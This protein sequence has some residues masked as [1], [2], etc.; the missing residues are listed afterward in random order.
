MATDHLTPAE[1]RSPDDPPGPSLSIG[2]LAARSGVAATTL[3][4]W[5]QRFGF[6]APVRT[7]GGQRRYDAA[8]VA[9]VRRVNRARESG[10]TLGAAI[11]V[12]DMAG[13]EGHRSLFADLR[14][15]HPHVDPINVS[16]R[17]MKALTWSIE[18]ECLAHA[19]RPQL[20]GCF[21]DR[22]SFRLAGRRWRE[23]AR[24]ASSAT[25]FSDFPET[26]PGATPAHVA[27]PQDSP[28]LNEW[29]LVCADRQMSVVLSA[30]EPPRTDSGAPRR[31][32]ALL[33]LEPRVVWDAVGF[34]HDTAAR[35]GLPPVAAPSPV[36]LVDTE[37][38]P[39]RSASLL[40]R[41][42][43]YADS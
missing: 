8:D 36:V 22:R 15:S 39:R 42:A 14:S 24:S 40:R 43:T 10:L 25:V 2:E 4:S 19:T 34:C 5:E 23:L 20:F 21:Q 13:H 35:L 16:I 33:S 41:F 28:M 32:E 37:E 29:F 11:E 18:D 6:P 31:F 7:T 27:L 12:A 38:D 17:V 3:R 1:G 30:W 26:D 9:R